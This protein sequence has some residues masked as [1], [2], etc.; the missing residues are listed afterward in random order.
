MHPAL[1]LTAAAVLLTL[2][3]SLVGA[4]RLAP[5]DGYDGA[6]H[7]AY[8]EV[9]AAEG[10][11]P[12]AE[13]S[14]EFTTPP[15]FAYAA[16]QLERV[17]GSWRAAQGLSA[18]F[19]AGLV[20]VAALLARELWPGHPWRW[21]GAAALT[22]A[23]PIVTRLGAMFHPEAQF[24]FLAALGAWLVVRASRR[25][26][27]WPDG[28]PAGAVLGL[29]AL[30]RPTAA[31]V[32]AALGACTLV[33]GRRRA[34]P[35]AGATLVALLVVAGPWWL[36]QADRYGNPFETNLDRYI[37]AD[38]QP[39]EFFVSAPFPELVTRPYRPSFAGELWPQLHADLWSDWFGGQHRFWERPP[40]GAT[41]LALSSQSLLGLLAAP[42]LVGGVVGLAR[43]R[44][45]PGAALAALA[46]LSWAAFLVQLVRFP[47]EGGDPIK[48]SYMLYL[49]P[50]F[51]LGGVAAATWLAARGPAWRR[52]VAAWCAL[53]A[54][55]FAVFLA[56]SWP[57]A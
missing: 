33:A 14:Y 43:T 37:I 48:A 52:A 34:L 5:H 25:G 24:A 49:A 42:A 12:T 9:L 44:R 35:F 1:V 27:P 45:F 57:A 39:R 32:I 19:A 15:A 7:V 28:L 30:T 4:A 23:L 29:A 47:Q 38:G 11:L 41:R 31:V 17:T 26:W 22:A 21:A 3:V 2:A 40:G 53:Y 36:R 51:A 20:L 8:A 54:V 46:A 6:A 56:T 16:V 55:S 13:E 50:V 10:R 18:L